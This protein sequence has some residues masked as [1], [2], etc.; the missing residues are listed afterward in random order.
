MPPEGETPTPAG[1]AQDFVLNL[2]FVP[3]WA[4]QQPA[5]NPYAG[6]EGGG[7]DESGRED[8]RDARG[9]RGGGGRREGGAGGNRGFRRD[10]RR[11]GGAPGGAGG[12]RKPDAG[13]GPR[14]D[15]R[16]GPRGGGGGRDARGGGRGPR[17]QYDARG[18]RRDR[19]FAPRLPIQVTFVPERNHLSVVVKEIHEKRRAYPLAMVAGLFLQKPENHQIKFEVQGGKDRPSDLKLWQNTKTGMVFLSR[20]VAMNYAIGHDLEEFFERQDLAVE[21]PSGNFVCVGRCTLSGELLGPPNHHGYQEKLQELHRTR[22][23][24]MPLDE[25]RG[26]IEMVRDPAA[27]EQWKEQAKTV[28]R[29]RDRNDPP[30]EA[31]LKR[32]EAEFLFTQKYTKD[33]LKQ[34]QRFLVPGPRAP[35]L[36]DLELRRLAREAWTRENRFPM[37][38]LFALRAAFKHMKLQLFKVGN[39]TFATAIAPKPLEAAH[40]VENIQKMIDLLREHPGWTRKELVEHMQP[41]LS[42]ES[43]EAVELLSP[44]RW[45]VDKGHVIEFF[46]GT[47][48]LPAQPPPRP[49]PTRDPSDARAEPGTE[50]GTTAEAAAAAPDAAPAPEGVSAEAPAAEPEAAPE[51][52]PAAAPDP[53]AEEAGTAVPVAPQAEPAPAGSSAPPA[54]TG[55][56]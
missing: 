44:L 55:Q 42:S 29:Y 26:R 14:R 24:H 13:R 19:D 38:L 31:R 11:G 7:R 6:A 4:R 46:N 5:Q 20:E 10:D 25:Y 32:S 15:D 22:F 51:A 28:R 47:L 41:G 23:A 27:V 39:E 33:L 3:S 49:A 34:G 18:P 2:N 48:S 1:G 9:G 8:R 43:P 17:D 12:F 35:D 36:P 30:G 56:A 37:T 54:G 53:K 50:P 16:Q 52:P 21:A 45:L 40:V